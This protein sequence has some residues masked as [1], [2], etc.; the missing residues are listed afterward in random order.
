MRP[1]NILSAV[2]T[3]Q[4]CAASH[5]TIT[6][7][8]NVSQPASPP[9]R[10]SSRVNILERESTTVPSIS[11]ST[12]LDL[13]AY[14]ETFAVASCSVRA[15]RQSCLKTKKRSSKTRLQHPERDVGGH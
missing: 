1:E 11:L 8:M 12:T 5:T 4:L 14:R 7:N 15:P 10:F 3:L 9:V 13:F 2:S 6:T